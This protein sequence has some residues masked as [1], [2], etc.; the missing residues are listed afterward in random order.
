MTNY[1]IN[2]H[3]QNSAFGR[4]ATV[5][6]IGLCDC[7]IRPCRRYAL[8]REIKRVC[9]ARRGDEADAY[10]KDDAIVVQ[11]T[12]RTKPAMEAQL[13]LLPNPAD[14]PIVYECEMIRRQWD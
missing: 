3:V 9:K 14:I 11:V 13:R 2:G 12:L 5:V 4:N 8:L 7:L 1:Y 10:I 6:N